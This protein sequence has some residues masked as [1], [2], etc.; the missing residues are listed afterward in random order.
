MCVNHSALHHNETLDNMEV[1]QQ[2]DFK[3][4]MSQWMSRQL[5]QLLRVFHGTPEEW[6]RFHIAFQQTTKLCNFSN[7]ENMNRFQHSLKRAAR[8]LLQGQFYLPLYIPKIMK[9]LEQAF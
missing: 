3:I 9:D 1:D 7:D 4:N 5:V 2:F 6:Q 8:E